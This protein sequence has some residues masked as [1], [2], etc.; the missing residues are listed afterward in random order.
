MSGTLNSCRTAR[1]RSMLWPLIARSIS[2]SASM[3]RTASRASGEI[4]LAGLPCAGHWPRDQPGQRTAGGHAPS[5]SEGRQAERNSLACM[6]LGLA[7][8]RLMPPVLLEHD[9]RPQARAGPATGDHMK[10]GWRLADLL[11]VA[12][13]ELTW[14]PSRQATLFHFL[15]SIRLCWYP[16]LSLVLD[17]VVSQ[18]VP[19]HIRSPCSATAAPKSRF[20]R[21]QAQED[22][23]TLLV[24]D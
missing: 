3:R 13:G 19:T 6:A 7:V 18:P 1:R 5:R 14:A 15:N 2:N 4:T 21:A 10:G 16:G 9:H 20:R 17:L 8:Q 11:A 23:T 12:A 24:G 22:K